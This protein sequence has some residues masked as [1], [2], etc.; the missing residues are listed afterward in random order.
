MVNH[1]DHLSISEI[2]YPAFPNYPLLTAQAQDMQS[3]FNVLIKSNYKVVKML[4][5]QVS[6][7]LTLLNDLARNTYSNSVPFIAQITKY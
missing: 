4:Q 2:I 6:D 5:S 7:T 1:L 3:N